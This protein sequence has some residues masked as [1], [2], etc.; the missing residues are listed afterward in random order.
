MFS[1][2]PD[3]SDLEA[4]ESIGHVVR[5]LAP[6]VLII[7]AAGALLFILAGAF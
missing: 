2:K 4:A 5:F 3:Y 7:L 6:I 1:M